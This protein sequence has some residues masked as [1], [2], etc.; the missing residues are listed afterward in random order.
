MKNL[1]SYLFL[2]CLLFPGTN[3]L[4]A[5]SGS[6]GKD[7]PVE[8]YPDNIERE[9]GDNGFSRGFGNTNHA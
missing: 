8:L 4:N 7:Y 3:C 5:Q 6:S 9:T 2:L 1:S